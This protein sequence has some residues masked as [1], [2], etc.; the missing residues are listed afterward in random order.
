MTARIV[1]T[2]HAFDLQK[3]LQESKQREQ[4]RRRHYSQLK[5]KNSLMNRNRFTSKTGSKVF[6]SF[7]KKQMSS[8]KSLLLA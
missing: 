7:I 6:Q 4:K 2:K 3:F 8:G 1:L 5:K